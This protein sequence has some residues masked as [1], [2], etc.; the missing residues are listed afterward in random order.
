[1]EHGLRETTTYLSVYFMRVTHNSRFSVYCSEREHRAA[2]P[3]RQSLVVMRM[4]RSSHPPTSSQALKM[5]WHNGRAFGVGALCVLALQ[6]PRSDSEDMRT[7]R[8]GTLD[9]ERQHV[10]GLIHIAI[11]ADPVH[12]MVVTCSTH[13]RPG[14]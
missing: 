8:G 5:G 10:E 4:E 3:S 6:A 12:R 9:A 14:G 1:V 2:A 11:T 13:H 7:S